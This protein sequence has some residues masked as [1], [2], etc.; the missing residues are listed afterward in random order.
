[1]TK[2]TYDPCLLYI[3]TNRFGIIGLQTDNTLLL[4]DDTLATAEK[5]ELKKAKFIV[6]EREKLTL[7]TL[8]K[9]NRG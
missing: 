7:D 8:I 2:L 6:K 3:N 1:M 9:F 4:I 5:T